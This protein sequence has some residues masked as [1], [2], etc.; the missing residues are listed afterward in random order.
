MFGEKFRVDQKAVQIMF[1]VFAVHRPAS[2]LDLEKYFLG[3]PK[4]VHIWSLDPS[5]VRSND[6]GISPKSIVRKL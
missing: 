6:A 1:Y 4:K 3:L 5:F 2:R